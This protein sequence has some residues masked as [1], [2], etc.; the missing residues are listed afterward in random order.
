MFD[1]APR[2][3]IAAI[4]ALVATVSLTLTIDTGGPDH[5]THVKVVVQKKV[6]QTAPEVNLRDST[7]AGVTPEQADD[8]L[9]TPHGLVAPQP[10]AGAQSYRC[11]QRFVRN[12]SDRSPGTH[13]SQIV[14]HITVSN[15]GSLNAIHALFD[16]TSSSASSTL[17]LEQD[18]ECEQWVPFAKKAWTQGAFNSVSESIEIISQLQSRQ[19]W[20][21]AP[22]IKKGILAAIVRDRARARGIPLRLVD[23]VGCTPIAGITDHDRLECGNNHVDVGVGFPW[24]VFLK[25]LH[26]GEAKADAIVKARRSHRIVHAKIAKR[27]RGRQRH[28]HGCSLLFK[29]NGQLHAKYG[30]ALG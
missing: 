24:D 27:C 4:I 29:R 22:I 18:G 23:P 28:S 13:V 20:L 9:V 1:T 11:D 5:Q 14:L 7:P 21:A 3:I 16:N 15:P 19:A 10:P 17:G 26:A 12:Y 6:Q 2:R 30:K 8:A 25:Q